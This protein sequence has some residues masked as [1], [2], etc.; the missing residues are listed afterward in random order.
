MVPITTIR[1]NIL[2]KPFPFSI[3]SLAPKNEPTRLQAAIGKANW[4]KIWPLFAKNNIE[5][6]LVARFTNLAWALAFKKSY[7]KMLTKNTTKKLPAPGPIKP[8]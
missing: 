3:A 8:S 5:P 2:I 1:K 6:V 7:P 4:Y